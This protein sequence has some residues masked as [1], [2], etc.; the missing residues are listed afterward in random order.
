MRFRRLS[1]SVVLFL[2]ASLIV[3]PAQANGRKPPRASD[4]SPVKATCEERSGGHRLEIFRARVSV[5]DKSAEKLSILNGGA[6]EQIAISELKTLTLANA[7]VDPDGFMKATLVRRDDNEKR[8][9]RVKV[10]SGKA[11]LALVGFRQDG[12]GVTIGL[13]R[14]KTVAFVSGARSAGSSEG[15]PVMKK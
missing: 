9:V 11:N 14:C 4:I 15:Q 8:S 12:A 3:A 1:I 6:S 2:I 5:G 13:S 7:R 10:R